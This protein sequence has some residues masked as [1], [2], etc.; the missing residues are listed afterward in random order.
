MILDDVYAELSR[1]HNVPLHEL[2]GAT[3]QTVLE[4]LQQARDERAEHAQYRLK[5]QEKV[6]VTLCDA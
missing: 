1:N 3:L 2:N 6:F 4:L 5:T